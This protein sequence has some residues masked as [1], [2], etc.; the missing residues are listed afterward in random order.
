MDLTERLAEKINELDNMP[1]L[2]IINYLTEN[3]GLAIYPVVGSATEFADWAGN[4]TKNINYEVQMRGTDPSK[5]MGTMWRIASMLDSLD[6]LDSANGSYIFQN[7]QITNEPSLTDVDTSNHLQ[8]TL[9]F[10]VTI[11]QTKGMLSNGRN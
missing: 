6:S 8:Y 1:Y 11:Y 4:L 2:C 9:G 7:L 10:N 5:C 3:T